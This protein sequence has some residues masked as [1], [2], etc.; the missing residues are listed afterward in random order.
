MSRLPPTAA[1]SSSTLAPTTPLVLTPARSSGSRS[2]MSSRRR[3]TSPSSTW[4]TRALP[5]V[6]PTRMPSLSVTL[7]SRAT[8]LPSASLSPRTWV[9]TVSVLV[10]SPS[11]APMPTR[12]SV[13]TLSSRSSSDL[14][15]PT[16]IHGARIAS[17]ILNS[18]TLYKQWLGEVKEMADRIITMRALLK[19]N[20]EKLGSKHDWSH[21]TNQIGM[22]AY[23]G[24]TDKEMTRLAEEFSVYATKDGRISV[25]GITS[26]NVGRLAEAIYKVKG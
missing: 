5:A 2:L 20:L 25:A 6:T 8:T 21:I 24:L 9:S 7:S 13:S 23:T 19:D 15:T 12:R 11:S 14:C 10:P 17:E 18:P 26:E 1:S 16:P 3:A 22:F 4:P